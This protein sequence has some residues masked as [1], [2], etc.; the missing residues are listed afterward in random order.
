MA[1]SEHV[2]V[3]S[4]VIPW[5]LYARLEGDISWTATRL[6]IPGQ[7]TGWLSKCWRTLVISDLPRG[8]PQS[9]AHRVGLTFMPSNP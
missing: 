8:I 6:V 4:F 5:A 9:K 2:V 1:G 7:Q 3:F